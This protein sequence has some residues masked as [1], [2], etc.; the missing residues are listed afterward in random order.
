MPDQIAPSR[1]TPL[2]ETARH[3]QAEALITATG[4]RI[5]E[6]GGQAFYHQG[7]DFIRL[8][9]RESFVSQPDFYCTALHELGHWTAHA[10]RL[11]R[12]LRA[13][14]TGP[15]P[16]RTTDPFARLNGTLADLVS[17]ICPIDGMN[18]TGTMN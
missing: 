15:H 14:L 13:R 7:E 11:D 10:T 5:V 4:A 3:P 1:P 18:A 6:G 2:P 9:Y 12:D 16:G 17:Q 8:P